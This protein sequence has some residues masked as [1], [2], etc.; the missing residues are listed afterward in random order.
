M[1]RK[2]S[3]EDMEKWMGD[4]SPVPPTGHAIKVITQKHLDI[5]VYIDGVPKLVGR[6]KSPGS[7]YLVVADPDNPPASYFTGE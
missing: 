5:Y 3:R 7:V 4:I 1:S 6:T 2:P